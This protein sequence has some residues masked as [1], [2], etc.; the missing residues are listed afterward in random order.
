MISLMEARKQKN[1][2]HPRKRNPLTDDRFEV[3]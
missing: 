2:Q 3:N 1:R